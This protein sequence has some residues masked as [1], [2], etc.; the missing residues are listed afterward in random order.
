[1]SI[2]LNELYDTELSRL[3]YAQRT[4]FASLS[5]PVSGLACVE[6]MEMCGSLSGGELIFVTGCSFRCEGDLLRL[7]Q[8]AWRLN[9][10]AVLACTGLYIRDIPEKITRF[11]AE[12]GL[13]LFTIRWEQFEFRQLACLSRAIY[14][15]EPGCREAMELE[16]AL[17]IAVTAPEEEGAYV[18]RFLKYGYSEEQPLCVGIIEFFK[19]D[20][21]TKQKSFPASRLEEILQYLKSRHRNVTVTV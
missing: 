7:L 18:P 15:P 12:S 11:C 19:Y 6:S 16:E 1:M 13:P 21:D 14:G 17:R 2:F 3:G 5:R 4:D 8:T 20:P 10:S 9:C